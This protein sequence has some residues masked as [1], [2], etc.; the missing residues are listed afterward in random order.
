MVKFKNPMST[1]E[2][3]VIAGSV[4]VTTTLVVGSA[5]ASYHKGFFDAI[6]NQ[7]GAGECKPLR[8][9]AKLKDF[10]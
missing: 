10:K 8:K 1:K 6:E 5:I 2:K 3:V 9:L 7:V 4:A